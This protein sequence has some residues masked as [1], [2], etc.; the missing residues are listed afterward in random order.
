MRLDQGTRLGSFEVR[1]YIGAGG[2]GEVYRARD[3]RLDRDVAIK[4]LSPQYSSDPEYRSRLEREAKVIARINHPNICTIHDIGEESGVF[5]L[6]FECLEGATLETHLAKGP[7]PLPQL[8]S[9]AIEVADALDAAHAKG[10]IHRDIKPA[11]IFIT[12]VGH[13]KV[14]DFGLAKYGSHAAPSSSLDTLTFDSRRGITAG[15]AGYM[16]PEQI[17]GR[18]LDGRSDLFS[19]GIV[20]YRAATGAAPFSGKTN[21]EISDAVLHRNPAPPSRIDPALPVALEQVV[22]K[23]LEKDPDLRYQSAAEMR[24]DLRRLKRDSESTIDGPSPALTG[25]KTRGV[26]AVSAAIVVLLIIAAAILQ[27]RKS[28]PVRLRTPVQQQLTANPPELP[29]FTA[30]ISADGKHLAY[31]ESTGFYIRLLDSGETDPLKLPPG[32]CFR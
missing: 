8:L 29:V 11:N 25:K 7:L 19:L 28:S 24:T 5:Y 13:A 16:S 17:L 21:G 22:L 23:S 6:V 2:M 14:L 30:A 20:I 12:R 3:A 31:S 26:Y 32:F 15:T 18:Q 10:I 9:H 4:I 1:E 27:Y